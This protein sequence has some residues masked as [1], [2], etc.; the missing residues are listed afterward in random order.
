MRKFIVLSA[1]LIIV[2]VLSGC[3][4][5]ALGRTEIDKLFIVRIFSIDEAQEGKV[6]I[7][8]TT[9]SLSTGGGGQQMAQKGES[10]VAEGDSV[11]EAVR[12]LSIYLDRRPNFGH[13]EY[14]IFGEAISRKGIL[15]YLDF[16]VRQN[17]IR[18]SAKL[19]IAK[20]S[21]A[22]SIVTKANTSKM[23]V[24]DRISRIEEDRPLTS[25]FSVI[26]LN[27]ASL[28]F[29]DK[30]LSTF[31]P[32]IELTN[33]MSSED[34]Q[35]KYDV[36]LSG[37]AIFQ[38]DKLSYFTPREEARGVNWMMNRIESGIILVKDKSG[39]ETALEIISS[40]VK[41]LPKIEGDELHCTVDIS[42]TTNIGEVMGNESITC[43]ESIKYLT[44]Q[45]KKAIKKEVEGTIKIAQKNN[46]DHFS[47]ISKFILKYPMLRDYLKQNWKA[48]F[49]DIKFDIKVKSNIKGTYLINDPVGSTGPSEGE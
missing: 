30:N 19:Y 4:Q 23:F 32:F 15:P 36:S 14:I 29:G 40:K 38:E 49:P 26:T 2:T 6:R 1:L 44:E 7:T 13:T 37:Y 20:G 12:N 24:G 39:E 10:V 25:L 18:S 34:K 27:E 45:Q 5:V 43:A 35:D 16:F 33:T 9:K 17:D 11:F 22:E 47:V 46:S 42:F 8:I 28:I 31:I 41:I 3:I 48:L 21:T